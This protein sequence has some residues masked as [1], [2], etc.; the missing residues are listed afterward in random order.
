MPLLGPPGC[1]GNGSGGGALSLLSRQVQWVA[2]Q[3]LSVLLL[4][5]TLPDRLLTADALVSPCHAAKLVVWAQL[6]C[7]QL[8]AHAVT[9]WQPENQ[10]IEGSRG[11]T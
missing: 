1:E 8:G 6:L 9:G 7:W 10:S 2:G 4:Q 3:Q 11:T 5:S